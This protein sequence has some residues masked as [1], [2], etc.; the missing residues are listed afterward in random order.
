MLFHLARTFRGKPCLP[1]Q[2]A[3]LP[4]HREF[5]LTKG[6]IPSP[7]FPSAAWADSVNSCKEMINTGLTQQLD[8]RG[9]W[10]RLLSLK[11]RNPPITSALPDLTLNPL[12]GTRDFSALKSPSDSAV[13]FRKQCQSMY[14]LSLTLQIAGVKSTFLNFLFFLVLISLSLDHFESNGLCMCQV[15][16][17]NL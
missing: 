17:K 11:N 2:S 10:R 4:Q 16:K 1:F 5:G 12:W 15:K 6:T 9:C 14:Y 3:S 8:K 13:G 7:P